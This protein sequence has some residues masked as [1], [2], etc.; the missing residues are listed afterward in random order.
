MFNMLMKTSKLLFED[1][2]WA[3]LGCQSNIFTKKFGYWEY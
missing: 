1:K 2:T 3:D